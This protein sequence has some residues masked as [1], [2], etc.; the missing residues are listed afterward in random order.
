M[1]C[2][3]VWREIEIHQDT[4]EKDFCRSIAFHVNH[5]VIN[6]ASKEICFKYIEQLRKGCFRQIQSLKITGR[7][8]IC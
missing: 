8:N 6:S 1:I 3:D 4:E 2:P 5:M 7:V